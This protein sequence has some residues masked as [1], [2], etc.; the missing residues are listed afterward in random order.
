MARSPSTVAGGQWASTATPTLSSITRQRGA[1]LAACG[2]WPKSASRLVICTWP[3]ACIDPPI[4][5]N[6]ASGAPSRIRKPGMMVWNGRLPGAT[7]F[8]W[9]ASRL[10]PQPRLCSAMPVPGTTTPDPKPLKF[11]WMYDT[12][13]PLR[14][15]AVR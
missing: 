15:A 6:E 14:S 9:P 13:I 10:K 8:G 4:T 5:P 3:C 7:W 2:F 1:S 11:D 12:I